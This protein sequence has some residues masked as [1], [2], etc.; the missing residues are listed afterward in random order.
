VT[1]ITGA[2]TGA[3]RSGVPPSAMPNSK[4]HQ[5]RKS[6]RQQQVRAAAESQLQI[7]REQGLVGA[8][9]GHCGPVVHARVVK[10]HFARKD[11]TSAKENS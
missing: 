7:A 4:H 6:E 5:H 3:S 10:R 8:Q 2:D 11:A 1:Q 9:G